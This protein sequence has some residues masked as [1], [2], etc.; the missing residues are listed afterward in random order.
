MQPTGASSNE[1]VNHPLIIE[2]IATM[3]R[4]LS[5]PTG[6]L[7]L[8]LTPPLRAEETPPPDFAR[9]VAPILNKYC[10]GCH[11]AEDAE[12]KLNLESFAGLEAGGKRGPVLMPGRSEASRLLRVLTGKAKPAMPPEGS[13]KL[14]DEEIALLARW[15]DAG[16]K[17][18]AGRQP[19]RTKLITPELAPPEDLTKAVSGLAFS[20]DGELL[21]V[22]RFREVELR[23]ADGN[24]ELRAIGKYPG[25]V[26]AV[27]FARDGKHLITASGVAGLYGEA[28][29]WKVADGKRAGRFTAHRDTLYDAELSPDG[30]RLATAGYDRKIIL[31]DVE[32]GEQL[33]TLSG[34]NDAVY[35]VA[36]NPAGDVLVSASGDETIKLW[37]V[38]TGERLDTRSEPLAEQYTTVFRPGGEYFAAGGVDN[39]IRVWR[40]VSRKGRKINPILHSRFAHDAPIVHLAFSPEG[41]VL[42]SVAEDRLIKLWETEDYRQLHVYPRQPDQVAALAFSPD[43]KSLAAGRMD[44]SLAV[45]PVKPSDAVA[46]PSR[47]RTRVAQRPSESDTIQTVAEREPNDKLQQATPLEAPAKVTGVVDVAA[48][49]KQRD[50]DEDLFRFR[51]KA[52]E[53]WILEVNAART[54][55]PL[56]SKIDVLD[57]E[58]KPVERL[59]L[60]AVRDTY[61]T[62]RGID[63]DNRQFRLHNWE[64]MELNQYLY[65]NGEVVRLFLAP[66]G[67][68]SGFDMY[69]HAGKRW[70]YFD[71]TA[72][73]HPLHEPCYIVEP[74][75]PGVELPPGGLPV[76]PLY[77]ENDD[78]GRRKLGK[79]SRLTFTAPE[80]GEYLVRVRDV[81]GAAGPKFKYTLTVRRPMP[82]FKVSLAGTNPQVPAGSGQKFTVNLERIDNFEGPV[83]VDI[84]NVPEGFVVTTPIVVQA[85]HIVAEGMIFALPG[86]DAPSEKAWKQ[87]QVTARATVAG[88]KVEKSAGNLGR[89]QLAAPPKLRVTLAPPDQ[90]PP[91]FAMRKWQMLEPASAASLG[92]ATLEP[93][94]DHSL[95]ASG[96]NPETDS[97][98]VV[99]NTELNNIRALRIEMLGE[100][101]LPAGG[102][103][104][105]AES[106]NFVLSEVR[107][108]AFP[109]GKPEEQQQ[110]AWQGAGAD[111]AQSGFPAAAA[112]DG[113]AETGWAVAEQT[114]D[115]KWH[116]RRS[117]GDPS[118]RLT[119][120]PAEPVGFAGGTTLVLTLEQRSE[121]P[122]HNLGRV[123]ILAT[124][125]PPPEAPPFPELTIKPGESITATL[126]VERRGFD[127]R[128]QFDPRNLPHGVIVDNIG[129]NGVLIPEGQTERT[130]FLTADPWVPETSR[131]IFLETR[132]EGNPTTWPV[133][134]RVAGTPEVA[135]RD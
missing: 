88:R 2:R 130:I 66:R 17:G 79:D 51:S 81:R 74:H 7:L 10:A 12:G 22:A 103:G 113:K 124:S 76:F 75:P 46:E 99:L 50:S 39:R 20:P 100:K 9:E 110:L 6:F 83:H 44:G 62:F 52:G 42:A 70:T 117:G 23:S 84:Q 28:S 48:G 54:G 37:Q 27:H 120:A 118:H 69:P 102:P 43:G 73:S 101:S 65:A 47:R 114:K 85:G 67:P 127:G 109:R 96:V 105:A 78:D 108:V 11:N 31:W 45:Y 112:I 126:R 95:L 87:V 15:I 72:I 98:T 49:E 3:P 4:L 135:Q 63:S 35:D 53:Q 1:V 40:L 121:K 36:F 55:S 133:L 61:I 41:K 80:E 97:Y 123:R 106:G 107:A 92:G 104:R 34:H 71:T 13:E 24:Q 60:R 93:L 19:D 57:L 115:K 14:S 91:A 30:K 5:Y 90:S 125:D 122:G 32:R 86:A 21:A 77:F 58:G 56:D 132:V 89:I 16:A 25:K 68:D 33:R 18:P 26:N 29:I 111:F 131:L 8:L 38:A 128:I 82:D 119:L 116:V 129:L 59:Q 134:L 94:E 64:E